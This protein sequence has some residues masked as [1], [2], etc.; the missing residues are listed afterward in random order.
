MVDEDES[1]DEESSSS[2]THAACI[3]RSPAP[4]PANISGPLRL[5]FTK[6]RFPLVVS[7]VLKLAHALPPWLE[8]R[9]TSPKSSSRSTQSAIEPGAC[10]PEAKARAERRGRETPPGRDRGAEAPPRDA[11]PAIYATT[12][13][14]D[15]AERGAR[16]RIATDAERGDETSP[17]ATRD[18]ADDDDADDEAAR[19]AR[20]GR[21]RARGAT[22][23]EMRCASWTFRK[24][25]Q[26]C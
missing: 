2:T 26:E 5:V 21:R 16:R 19:R 11:R 12:R 18:I 4:S 20:C 14:R 10:A 7:S 15:A 6:S 25:V 1:E 8:T 3:A 24:F 9:E 17:N 13:R 23:M 22:D